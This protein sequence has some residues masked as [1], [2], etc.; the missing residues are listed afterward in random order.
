M[1]KNKRIKQKH[2]IFY[3][4][5][6]SFVELVSVSRRCEILSDMY[7]ADINRDELYLDLIDFIFLLKRAKTNGVSLDM[8]PKGILSYLALLGPE[9]YPTLR[10]VLKKFSHSACVCSKM[11]KII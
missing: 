11:R 6:P 10:I 1:I 9:A 4:L 3:F 8:E 5:C 7:R 2:K